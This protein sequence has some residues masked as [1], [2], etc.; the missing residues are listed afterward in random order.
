MV[1]WMILATPCTG[2]TSAKA[3]TIVPATMGLYSKQKQQTVKHM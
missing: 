3:K 2:E 1:F